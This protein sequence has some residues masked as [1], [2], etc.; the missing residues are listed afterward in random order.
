VWDKAAVQRYE[1]WLQ[2]PEGAFALG[3][4]KR[5]LAHLISGWPR[6]GQRLLEVG[7]GSGLFLEMFWE[8]GFDTTGLDLSPHM[9]AA[10]RARVNTRVDLHLGSADLLPFD[11]KEF[12]FVALITV[13]EFVPDPLA[14]LEEAFRVAR[15]G[16]L[17][18]FLNRY[19]LYYLGNGLRL[20]FCRPSNLRAARWFT[21]QEMRAQLHA[22]AVGKT[23]TSRSVLPGPLWSWKQTVPW[24]W[25]NGLIFPG[26][27]G[28]WCATRVDFHPEKQLTP[29]YAFSAQPRIS[30]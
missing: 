6:R 18:A 24:R 16:L 21:P 30:G 7:C 25:L 11:D 13:L 8:A 26:C 29:L 15:K 10:A 28:A 14:A 27:V 9:L 20:P 2:T 3:R 1:E 17:V 19:S 23:H 22:V 12:D 4:E 5:L